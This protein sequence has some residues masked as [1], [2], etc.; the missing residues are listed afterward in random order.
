MEYK[1]TKRQ[2]RVMSFELRINSVQCSVGVYLI[3][4]NYLSSY[5]IFIVCVCVLTHLGTIFTGW[6][7]T[8][9]H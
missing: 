2:S 6:H 9:Q 1:N 5:L 3:F 7:H 8:L 4:I